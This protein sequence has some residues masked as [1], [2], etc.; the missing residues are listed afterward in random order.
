MDRSILLAELIRDEAERLKPYTD[1]VGKLTIG[2]GRNLSDRGIS[3]EESRY[4]WNNDIDEVEKTLDRA[5]G[6][7][8][9]LTEA[10]QRVL[11]NMCF[12][13][14]LSRLLLFRKTLTAIHD[15]NYAEAAREMLESKWAQQVGARA[16]RLAKLMEDG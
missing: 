6:W 13:L 12:N 1:T 3:T 14:G 16:E 5:F 4:L 10:R 8:R 11:V 15:G 2:I 9:T 7:W